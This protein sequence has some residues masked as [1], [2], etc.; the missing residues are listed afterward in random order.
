MPRTTRIK[1]ECGTFH[2]TMRGNNKR[3]LFYRDCEFRRFKSTLMRYTSK[4]HVFLHHYCLMINHVH[5]ALKTSEDTDLSK[6]MQG[7]ELSY[8]HYHHRIRNYVGHLWQGRF[9]SRVI[10]SDAYLLTSSLYIERNPVDA[11]VTKKP[12]DYPWSSYR[13][14]AFG[15]TDKLICNDPLYLDLGKN[16]EERREKYRNAMCRSIE[17]VRAKK[18]NE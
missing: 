2:I 18:C 5:L 1:P 7:I 13:H 9:I 15:E 16:A 3:R 10:D 8:Y 14:Y 11:S 6:F 17:S 4:H 12:E